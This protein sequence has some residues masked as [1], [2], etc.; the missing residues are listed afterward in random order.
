MLR[1]GG[2]GGD[3]GGGGGGDD[4]DGEVDDDDNDD[5][6]GDKCLYRGECHIMSE[7]VRAQTSPSPPTMLPTTNI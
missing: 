4:D 1:C 2:G 7:N 6:G 3:D 5:G